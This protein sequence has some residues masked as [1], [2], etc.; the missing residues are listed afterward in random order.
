MTETKPRQRVDGTDMVD[1]V[2]DLHVG[3]LFWGFAKNI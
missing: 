2:G 1:I 3:A